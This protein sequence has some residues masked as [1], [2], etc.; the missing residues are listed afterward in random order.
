LIR[1]VYPFGEK[2]S[3]KRAAGKGRQQ[4]AGHKAFAGVGDRRII[5]G[6]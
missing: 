2:K 6:P 4:A 3:R 1:V 5:G